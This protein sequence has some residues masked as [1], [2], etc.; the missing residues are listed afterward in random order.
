MPTAQGGEY[1]CRWR[2][3]NLSVAP[4]EA[5]RRD[6]LNDGGDVDGPS[7]QRQ[8]IGRFLSDQQARRIGGTSLC[9][10][11]CQRRSHDEPQRCISARRGPIAC[12]CIML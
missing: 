10:Q 5:H 4:D 3:G 7:R 12:C 9:Q 2:T 1:G 6:P 8:R 11:C